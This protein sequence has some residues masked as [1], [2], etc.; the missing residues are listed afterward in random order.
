MIHGIQCHRPLASI[1]QDVEVK[2][3]MGVHWLLGGA[4][5]L[6]KAASSVVIFFDK[7]LDFGTH[8]KLKG[9][10]HSIEAYDFDR[11]RKGKGRGS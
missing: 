8:L 9:R 2:G 4:R 7:V 10:W 11:G 1:I 5:R 6:G 3:T